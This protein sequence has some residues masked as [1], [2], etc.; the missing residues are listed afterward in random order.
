MSDNISKC[1][2]FRNTRPDGERG[3]ENLVENLK[4]KQGLKR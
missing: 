4:G 2:T 1:W 3:P